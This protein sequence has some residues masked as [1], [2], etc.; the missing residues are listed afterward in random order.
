MA[1]R[2]DTDAPPESEGTDM[3]GPEPDPGVP[4]ID[5]SPFRDGGDEGRAEVA[6]RIGAACERTGFLVITGHGVSADALD[7]IYRVTEEFFALPLE[8]KGRSTPPGGGL[9]R[10]YCSLEGSYPNLVEQFHASRFDT[11]ADAVAVGYDELFAATLEP[12]V[13][14]GLPVGFEAAWKGY[15]QEMETLAHTVMQAFAVAMG[16]PDDWF[17]DKLHGHVANLAA[18]YYPAQDEPPPPGQVR[19]APHTDFGSLTI[20]YQAD[21][22]NGLEVLDVDHTWVPV[23][24]LPGA[25]V[26]N[27]G[28][29]MARWTNDRWVATPHRVVNPPREVASRP[30]ISIPFFQHPNPDALIESIPTCISAARPSKYETI[31]AGDWKDYRMNT[32]TERAQSASSSL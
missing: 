3:A 30:R 27:L 23:P 11:P 16:L 12:N 8:E 17:D 15:F 10:G 31:R 7:A 18:N 1:R 26:V 28:D 32:Y 20:L 25:F 6:R 4:I 22:H 29:L 19:R 24:T 5:L 21:G 9:Y 14:P 13:W 2:G